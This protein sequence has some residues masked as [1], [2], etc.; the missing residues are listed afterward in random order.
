MR[1]FGRKLV[2]KVHL[3]FYFVHHSNIPVQSW[4][5]CSVYVGDLEV[6]RYAL[7]LL[8]YS[9]VIV[10]GR[11]VVQGAMI[12]SV[13]ICP[14]YVRKEGLRSTISF[15]QPERK[16]TTHII[17]AIATDLLSAARNREKGTVDSDVT[18]DAAKVN[19]VF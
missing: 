6:P 13:T 15:I 7:R 3:V 9:Q 1:P 10:L 17:F 11:L 2:Q 8:S 5:Q 16:E 4:S 18:G 19:P 12:Q 14:F